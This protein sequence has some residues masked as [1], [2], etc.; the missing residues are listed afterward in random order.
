M[1]SIE[2]QNGLTRGLTAGYAGETEF[3]RIKR[4]SFDLSSSDFQA[5]GIEYHDEW[6]RASVGGGQ[7][8]VRVNDQMFTRFYAGGVIE[9]DKLNN[10]GI[11]EKTIIGELVAHILELK[12][13]TR[14][15]SD[16]R[17]NAK[18][19]CQYDYK[20][21][22]PDANVPVTIAKETISYKGEVVFVHDFLLCAVR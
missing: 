3:T 17:P 16:C 1:T 9:E 2:I 5:D 4:A 8:L 12:D 15:F 14:L 6:L 11:T 10:L 18:G 21:I 13:K 19:D 22:D 20:L 7:E